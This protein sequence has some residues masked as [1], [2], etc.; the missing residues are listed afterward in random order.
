MNHEPGP[1]T[2]Q[3]AVSHGGAAPPGRPAGPRAP[4]GRR[5][6]R[7]G[8]VATATWPRTVVT[9]CGC[10]GSGAGDR[11]AMMSSGASAHRQHPALGAE[12]PADPVEAVD[13]VAEQLPQRHDQQV[14]DRVPVQRAVGRG[15]GAAAP[16]PRSGPSRRRRTARPAPS[17]GRPGGSTPS[18]RRS[19]P[20]E[21]PSSATVTT[22]VRSSDHVAQRRQ[23]RGQPVAAAE[24][25]DAGRRGCPPGTPSR[26]GGAPTLTPARGRGARTGVEARVAQPRGEL[27]GHRDAAVLA[28][29]AADG[30]RH[31]ALALAEVAGADGAEHVEVAVQELL[32]LR[33]VQ[34]VVA[35]PRRR[36][37]CSGRSSGTQCGLG[38]NRTSATR[39]ASTGR[40]Y[41]KPKDITVTCSERGVLGA[42]RLRDL[43]GQ[44]VHVEVGGVDDDVGLGAQ[45]A[46]HDPLAAHAVEQPAVALQR[47][48][49]ARGLEAADQRG[50]VGLEEEQ[51]WC[52]G[53]SCRGPAPP[54]GRAKNDPA[55]HVDDDRDPA[56]GRPGTRRPAGPC[57]AAAAGGRLSTTNQ[58]RSSSSLAAVLRPAPD[59]PVT[60]TSWPRR[61]RRPR[62]VRRSSGLLDL[63]GRGV[64]A[65]GPRPLRLGGERGDDRGRGARADARAPR[66]S[67]RRS[68]PAACAA[69][70]SA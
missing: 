42:E 45:V 8:V 17:A 63:A 38:R 23:R 35:R 51:A 9:S 2:T 29:G 6:T 52:C 61:P 34:H 5:G 1:S 10:A 62:R 21:P 20:R 40:P 56:A 27:L 44:L 18:S 12:Q 65:D 64:H 67:P 14:A 7:P 36:G 48:R 25:D 16:A 66:R 68:R 54:A 11:G 60:T 37:R 49:P 28:A 31:V 26:A 53:R 13:R 22:A 15:T 43:G 33:L 3:S 70:R 57:R 32:G 59:M 47:V 41:L 30:D 69:S 39:S 55:A 24:G 46:E 50:V 4:A 19:R 58:P